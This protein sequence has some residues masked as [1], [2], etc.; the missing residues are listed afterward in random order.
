MPSDKDVRKT[1]GT[2]TSHR[3]CEEGAEFIYRDWDSIKD[4]EVMIDF[5]V[6]HAILSSEV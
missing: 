4:R 3:N 6:L 5:E 1:D 2:H